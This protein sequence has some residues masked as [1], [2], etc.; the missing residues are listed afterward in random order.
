VIGILA[1]RLK[2]RFHRPCIAF[3]RGSA[4]EIKGSGR[5][6]RAL[7]LRDA[8]DLV[9]KREPDLVLRFGGHAAAAGL[10]VREADFERFAAAFEAVVGALLTPGD[11]ARVLE[12]DGELAASE[13]TLD[14]AAA[15]DA[16]VWGQGFPAPS[17]VGDFEVREQRIVGERHLKLRLARD[18]RPVEAIAFNHAG[19]LPAAVRAVYR[20]TVNEYNGQRTVQ[21]VVEH[22]EPA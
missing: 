6:I 21:L 14:A 1:S 3:A 9:T 19:P 10:T 20:L 8:L 17:F 22:C 12:T 4:G 18:G 11:L 15:L 16:P 13:L 5:S 7:H 2:D